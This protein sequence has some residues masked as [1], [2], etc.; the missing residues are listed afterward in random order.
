MAKIDSVDGSRFLKAVV[1]DDEPVVLSCISLLLKRRGYEVLAFSNPADS[2]VCRF[3]SCPCSQHPS[4]PD[5]VISDFDMPGINGV[6]VLEG[7][8]EKGCKCRHVAL[9][10]G[11]GLREGDLIRMAKYATR[12]FLKPIDFIQFYAWLDRVEHEVAGRCTA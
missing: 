11:K 8:F 9:I 6:E 1:I 2:P 4:C 5:L 10:S 3:R 12:Y 7:M